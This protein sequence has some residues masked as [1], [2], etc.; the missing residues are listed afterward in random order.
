V[1]R[2]GCRPVQNETKD[3]RCGN[4]DREDRQESETREQPSLGREAHEQDDR[5][6]EWEAAEPHPCDRD[7]G[8]GAERDLVKRRGPHGVE[9]VTE[10]D[11]RE[12]EGR[13]EEDDPTKPNGAT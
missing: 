9:Q 3:A 7:A 11:R 5:E 2:K 1:K 6:P 13:R 10:G 4:D 8:S 12:E